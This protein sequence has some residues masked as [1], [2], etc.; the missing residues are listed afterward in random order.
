MSKIESAERSGQIAVPARHCAKSA[1]KPASSSR[2][3]PNRNSVF[4]TIEIE[5]QPTSPQEQVIVTKGLK[6]GDNVVMAGALV[7]K[8]E[9]IFSS[10]PEE[11]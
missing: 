3:R 7:L 2:A 8:S 6:A 9:L 11:E 4:G 10:E 1:A 5:R